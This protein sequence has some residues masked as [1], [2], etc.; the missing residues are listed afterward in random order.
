MNSLPQKMERSDHSS[1]LRAWGK[2][3]GALP[4]SAMAST[5]VLPN[6]PP[7]LR[8]WMDMWGLLFKP[9]STGAVT[10]WQATLHS[11]GVLILAFLGARTLLFKGTKLP[12]SAYFSPSIIAAMVAHWP[13]ALALVATA[14][15]LW[16]G[17]SRLRWADLDPGVALHGFIGVIAGTLAWT[18]SVYDYNLYYDQGHYF[19]RFLLIALFAGSLWRPVLI[20]PFLTLVYAIVHQFDQPVS[21]T[22]TDKRALFDL[23]ALFVAFLG[24]RLW[25]PRKWPVVNAN[26]F[27]FLAIV[28]Q[29]SNYFFPGFGKLIMGW[30]VVE[31]LDNLFIASYLNGW[32]GF[33]SAEQAFGW[34]KFIA[35]WNPW[36]VWSSLGV[37]LIILFCLW[38]RRACVLMLLSCIGLHAVICLTTGILFWKWIIFDAALIAL[39]I[40]R[41]RITTEA[42]FAADRRW[43]S[44]ALI[45]A[46]P[47]YFDPPW[48]AWYD[49]ELNEIYHLEAV[50][51]S[52]KTFN[53]PRTLMT[54][55]EVFF[56]QNKFH[57]LSR[58]KFVNGRYGTSPHREV[59]RRL[60]GAPTRDIAEAVRNELGEMEYS[61][62]KIAAF[63]RFIQRYFENLNRRG[64]PHLIP[65]ILH[66]PQHIYSVIE[67]PRFSGQEAVVLVRVI[68]QRS[69]YQRDRVESLKRD[70]IR[71]ITIPQ[72]GNTGLVARVR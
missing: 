42:L 12:E 71:E 40:G 61:E 4:N 56:A 7:A 70:V 34:A 60:D 72:P 36:M 15:F 3:D 11:A 43:L 24:I 27:L 20:A 1:P 6:S 39:L 57:F 22:W 14:V 2:I 53:I 35:D 31:R 18:F 10:E 16:H 23:L 50:T 26:D 46:A 64:S 37:E 19:E 21:C 65:A 5:A 51:T 17:W 45:A 33:L 8:P 58:D 63:D 30:P 29:A 69:L 59:A 41:D 48:L 25:Q 54:P 52:G 9:R 66:P 38:N 62:K 47:F 28:L 49:T 44:I 68:H 55:Y 13:S 32:L 67:E